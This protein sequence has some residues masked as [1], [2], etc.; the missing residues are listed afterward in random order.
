MNDFLKEKFDD[1]IKNESIAPELYDLYKVKRGLRNNNGTGVLV[2]LTKVAEVSGYYV[3]NDV[4]LPKNGNLYYRELDIKEVAKLNGDD[5]GYENACFLLLFGHY[6]SKE[7]SKEFRK[8]LANEYDLPEGTQSGTT[9]TIKGKGIKNVSSSA[10]GNLNFTVIVDIPKKLNNEQREIIKKL[11]EV[12]GESFE[13][14][15][16]RRFF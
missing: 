6:P 5:F 1:L 8:L 11:A 3:E 12:S 15:R 16:K 9:F 13:S 10:V 14:G 7:E 4:K 2:G